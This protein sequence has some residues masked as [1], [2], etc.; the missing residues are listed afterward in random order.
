M[1]TLDDEV[2]VGTT[3]HRH[4]VVRAEVATTLVTS[5]RPQ[6]AP[7]PEVRRAGVG[8]RCRVVVHCRKYHRAGQPRNCCHQASD[9]PGAR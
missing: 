1:G 5:A 2:R 7:R 8:S 9:T 6:S 3:G 4:E